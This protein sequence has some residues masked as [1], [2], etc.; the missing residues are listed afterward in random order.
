MK[1]KAWPIEKPVK[2]N[3]IIKEGKKARKE[4][5]KVI[6]GSDR[7]RSESESIAIFCIDWELVRYYHELYFFFFFSPSEKTKKQKKTSIIYVRCSIRIKSGFYTFKQYFSFLFSLSLFPSFFLF[8][9]K[10]RLLFT[11]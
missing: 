6:K 4:R 3:N 8:F 7:S 1:Q 11:L 5:K 9:H 2:I 10:S